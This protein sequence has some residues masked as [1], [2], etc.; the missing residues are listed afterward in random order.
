MHLMCICSQKILRQGE[1]YYI[2]FKIFSTLNRN[3]NNQNNVN[4][5]IE[6][7]FEHLLGN[8]PYLVSLY[9]TKV[10]LSARSERIPGIFFLQK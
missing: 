5:N 2:L 1:K 4:A 3:L 8:I 10:K 6:A 7:V 9:R